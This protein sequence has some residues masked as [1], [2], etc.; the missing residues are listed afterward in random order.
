LQASFARGLSSDLSS[1]VSP[2]SKS[3]S[4]NLFRSLRGR[5]WRAGVRLR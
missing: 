5:A 1:P 3:L 4:R 2:G